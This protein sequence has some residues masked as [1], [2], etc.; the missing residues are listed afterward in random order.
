MKQGIIVGC[1]ANQEWLLEWWWRHYSKHN[2]YPVAFFDF[3]LS[4][5]GLRW[6]RKRGAVLSL[7]PLPPLKPVSQN[8]RKIWEERAGSGI[9]PFRAA[10][11]KKP[12]AF[13]RSPFPFSLWIDLDCEIRGNLEPLLNALALGADIALV[14]EPENVQKN[15][16]EQGITFPDEITYNSGIAAFRQKS[17]ILSQWA[18]LCFHSND[19]FMGDQNALSRAIYLHRPPLASLPNLFNWKMDQGF[20]NEALILHYISRWKLDLMKLLATELKGGEAPQKKN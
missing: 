5:S 4:E 3:G 15:D 1:D 17:S 18:D 12:H 16:R 11:F 9:W 13:L 2:A 7:P 6:C 10:W 14:P 19:E 20:Q 8:K